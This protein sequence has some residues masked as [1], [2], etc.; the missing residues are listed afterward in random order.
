MQC[1]HLKGNLYF[2]IFDIKYKIPFKCIQAIHQE[3]T[4]KIIHRQPPF[5]GHYMN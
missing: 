1:I 4:I 3:M 2:I 5:R